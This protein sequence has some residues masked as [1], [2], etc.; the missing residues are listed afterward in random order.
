MKR[1][2]GILLMLVAAGGAGVWWF[3]VPTRLGWTK[4]KDGR[5][6]IFGNVD[7]RQVQLGFRVGGRIAEQFTALLDRSNFCRSAAAFEIWRSSTRSIST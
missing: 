2:V 5:L 4:E 6:T 1:I 7:I 3:D